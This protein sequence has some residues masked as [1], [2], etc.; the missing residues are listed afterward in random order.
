MWM[1]SWYE[2]K[3]ASVVFCLCSTSLV[4]ESSWERLSLCNEKELLI[5]FNEILRQIENS[6]LLRW[7]GA[8][9]VKP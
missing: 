4:L 8:Q 9:R 6:A 2:K 3:E 7:A 1:V 5:K